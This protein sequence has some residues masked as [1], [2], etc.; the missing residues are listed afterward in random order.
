MDMTRL[1]LN[2][3]FG[4]LGATHIIVNSST[5][6][7]ETDISFEN[8]VAE[9]SLTRA[10][11]FTSSKGW[12]AL[13]QIPTA[14]RAFTV[15]QDNNTV[16]GGGYSISSPTRV[17]TSDSFTVTITFTIS[18]IPASGVSISL[19]L[20]DSRGVN[21]YYIP[22]TV[23]PSIPLATAEAVRLSNPTIEKDVKSRAAYPS[24]LSYRTNMIDSLTTQEE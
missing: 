20:D 6:L 23:T 1:F 21:M 24:T 13:A 10:F 14:N 19:T 4:D 9:D 8:R 7:L 15:K 3:P 12:A 22:I 17:G 5:F 11:T 16:P 18:N 2:N